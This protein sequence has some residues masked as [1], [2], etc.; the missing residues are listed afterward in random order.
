MQRRR[1]DRTQLV[2]QAIQVAFI[3]LN[4]W[5][6]AR[7]YLW[8]RYYETGDATTFVPRPPGVEGW[9]PIAALMN[10]KY[11]LVTGA[12]PPVH[13]AGLVLLVAFLAMSFLVRKAA[14]VRAVRADDRRGARGKEVRGQPSA[15]TPDP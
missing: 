1:V 8:V 12:L 14:A 4:L 11:V 13:A 9:L 2:R 5:I 6:G 3:A 15:L 10:L 7:F